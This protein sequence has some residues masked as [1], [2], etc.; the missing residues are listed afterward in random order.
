MELTDAPNA[1]DTMLARIAE[2]T[3]LA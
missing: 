2:R 3:P 1:V